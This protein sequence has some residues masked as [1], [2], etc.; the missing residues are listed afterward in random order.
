MTKPST[1]KKPSHRTF[2]RAKALAKTRIS[3]S[4]LAAEA[5]AEVDA[6][7]EKLG[8]EAAMTTEER[9]ALMAGICVPNEFTEAVAAMATR[10]P[11]LAGG[12]DSDEAREAIAFAA[13]YAP[14]ATAARELA[15]RV[16]SKIAARRAAAGA[17]ALDTYAM[18][19]GVVRTP[20]GAPLR[21]SLKNLSSLLGRSRGHARRGA[22]K[23]VSAS[24]D[25]T[26]PIDAAHEAS[27]AQG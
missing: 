22:T 5:I 23:P 11:D 17:R 6:L 19:K 21:D 3:Q 10:H 25:T 16:E 26:K 7:T 20:D 1:T 9:R 18:W 15:A 13:A 24:H 14:L 8:L 12:F 27:I 4:A 2:A